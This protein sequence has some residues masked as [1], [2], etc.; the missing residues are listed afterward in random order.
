MTISET[1]AKH[2]NCGRCGEPVRRGSDFLRAQRWGAVVLLHWEC[3]IQQMRESDQGNA[4]ASAPE[5]R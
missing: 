4:N 3:F 1:Q 5:Q 2:S